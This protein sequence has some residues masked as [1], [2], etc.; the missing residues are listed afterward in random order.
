MF[1]VVAIIAPALAR[2]CQALPCHLQSPSEAGL[3]PKGAEV[4]ASRP[5]AETSIPTDCKITLARGLSTQDGAL[6]RHLSGKS[7][8][9]ADAIRGSALQR[10]G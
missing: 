6:T 1:V 10:K 5:P 9:G 8:A 3:V 4:H 2:H 7:R